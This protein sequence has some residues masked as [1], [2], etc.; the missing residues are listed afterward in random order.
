M[1]GLLPIFFAGGLTTGGATL[2][3]PAAAGVGAD[4]SGP[5]C[6]AMGAGAAMIPD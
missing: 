3:R 6:V 5:V 1:A 2:G 4:S